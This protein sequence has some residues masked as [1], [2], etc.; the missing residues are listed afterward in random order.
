M[1]EKKEIFLS[2]K[3]SATYFFLPFENFLVK[4]FSNEEECFI[5]GFFEKSR[6]T[7]GVFSAIIDL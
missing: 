4:K 6:L 5:Q 3:K 1:A 2:I 7:R